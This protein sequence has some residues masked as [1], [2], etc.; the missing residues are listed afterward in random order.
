MAVI[1]LAAGKKA[2]PFFKGMTPCLHLN[3]IAKSNR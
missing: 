3:R 1:V 2:A